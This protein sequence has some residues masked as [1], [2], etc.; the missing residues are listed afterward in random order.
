VICR[1]EGVQ[2]ARASTRSPRDA[3]TENRPGCPQ[4]GEVS[5]FQDANREPTS[6]EGAPPKTI[7]RSVA[8]SEAC[9]S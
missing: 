1:F 7:A 2:L 8:A 3:I 9:R 4:L 6:N 5:R